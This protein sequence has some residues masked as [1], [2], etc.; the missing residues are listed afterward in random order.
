M[1]EWPHNSPR[2]GPKPSARI[3]GTGKMG[4][5]NHSNGTRVAMKKIRQQEA[6]ERNAAWAKMSP[7]EQM[8]VLDGTLGKGQGATKQR[9][10]IA[11]AMQKV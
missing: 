8:Q 2:N 7:R 3:G 5:V 1:P 4:K 6:L 10:R 9:K 11:A